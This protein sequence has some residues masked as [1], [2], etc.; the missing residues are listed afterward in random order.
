MSTDEAALRGAQDE[1]APS[2]PTRRTTRHRA[3]AARHS[4]VAAGAGAAEG[5]EGVATPPSSLGGDSSPERTPGP[6]ENSPDIREPTNS[7]ELSNL[8]AQAEERSSRRAEAIRGVLQHLRPPA[9]STA[10]SFGS[11][12][13]G[14]HLQDDAHL[15]STPPPATGAPHGVGASRLADIAPRVPRLPLP[16]GPT[17]GAGDSGPAKVHLQHHFL[18]KEEDEEPLPQPRAQ[19]PPP[20][21]MPLSTGG[22][23]GSSGRALA[24]MFARVGE[25][26]DSAQ[27]GGSAVPSSSSTSRAFGAWEA[28]FATS[29]GSHPLGSARGLPPTAPQSARQQVLM[30]EHCQ[31]LKEQLYR[32]ASL[33][34]NEGV[35]ARSA[36]EALQKVETEA[37][38]IEGSA[39]RREVQLR[40]EMLDMRGE[41]Q[42]ERER[43]RSEVRKLQTSLKD[44]QGRARAE[45]EGRT[46]AVDQVEALTQQVAGTKAE[47][48]KRSKEGQEAKASLAT[49]E[50]RITQYVEIF[51]WAA[52]RCAEA[53]GEDATQEPYVSG[54]ITS[55]D[56]FEDGFRRMIG[57][58][59]TLLQRRAACAD[60]DRDAAAGSASSRVGRGPAAPTDAAKRL[61]AAQCELLHAQAR[62][63]EFEVSEQALRRRLHEAEIAAQTPRTPGASMHTEHRQRVRAAEDAQKRLKRRAAELERDLQHE[64]DEHEQELEHLRARLEGLQ[65]AKEAGEEYIESEEDTWI[66]IQHQLRAEEAAIEAF[67][68]EARRA[69]ADADDARTDAVQARAAVHAAEAARRRIEADFADQRSAAGDLPTAQ[70]DGGRNTLEVSRLRSEIQL[71][72]EACVHEATVAQRRLDEW[73][74]KVEHSSCEAAGLRQSLDS[75]AALVRSLEERCEQQHVQQAR[76]DEAKRAMLHSA[77]DDQA[78]SLR[79]EFL[80]ALEE[81]KRNC[82]QERYM[83]QRYEE[84][85]MERQRR[86]ETMHVAVA[87]LQRQTQE[88][89]VQLHRQAR[90]SVRAEAYNMEGERQASREVEHVESE[91]RAHDEVTEELI[92]ARSAHLKLL[93][94]LRAECGA[95]LAAAQDAEQKAC[96]RCEEELLQTRRTHASLANFAEAAA[97]GEEEEAETARRAV[98]SSALSARGRRVAFQEELQ[99]EV[100]SQLQMRLQ[101][102]LQELHAHALE[103]VC[104]DVR[105]NPRSELR[106]ELC[107]DL[108]QEIRD[109]YR[110][111]LCANSA[112]T[113]GSARSGGAAGCG[114][115]LSLS[116][117]CGGSLSLSPMEL[118]SSLLSATARSPSSIANISSPA[119]H[120]NTSFHSCASPPAQ[121][122]PSAHP[123]P[124]SSWQTSPRRPPN[125]AL[126]PPPQGPQEAWPRGQ[127][128][129]AFT[130][131]LYDE[132]PPTHRSG[133]S[134]TSPGWRPGS[135]AASPRRPPP[136]WATGGGGGAI[137]PATGA[138]PGEHYGLLYG[139]GGPNAGHVGSPTQGCTS[140]GGSCATS[141]GSP[142]APYGSPLTTA[143]DSS[144]EDHAAA[145]LQN[146]VRGHRA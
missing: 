47:I 13:E 41:T 127:L 128:E 98:R 60:S 74:V 83:L 52:S 44:A 69:Q 76:V 106:R 39:T 102:E 84:E 53:L 26:I 114:G 50:A 111:E 103:E 63:E 116:Q 112:G 43:L 120:C 17:C 132:A 46:R 16:L 145:I 68:S 80:P 85:H 8:L 94:E 36:H 121:A 15:D 5:D 124:C 45:G 99:A 20:M 61:A 31:M 97:R 57:R 32:S 125:E 131:A 7:Q 109:Q 93:E 87:A 54:A 72:D 73:R 90:D 29:A 95:E 40:S 51:R 18:T 146:I 4:L 19:P 42:R 79:S 59:L 56:T 107:R 64:Q 133:A 136:A 122:T 35:A 70:L 58:T 75:K 30:Q 78:Q 126:R 113:P 92:E 67:R 141:N 137:A 14:R 9:R 101:A 91:R 37:A 117:G 1:W 2:T 48:M 10:G 142:I 129:G 82:E 65:R 28:S 6:A 81:A 123:A 89:E 12:Q 24:R 21:P 140:A 104:Q 71:R 23:A 66:R 134:L 27:D 115:S 62:S 119:P 108:R 34:E 88:L 96:L 11:A 38:F 55:T 86:Q 105:G 25:Q 130:Q 49:L 139:F 3:A 135:P 144:L 77:L 100:G 118:T 22:C 143:Y 110:S 33:A 138:S